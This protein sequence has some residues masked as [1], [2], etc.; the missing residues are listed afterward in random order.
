MDGAPTAP[1]NPLMKLPHGGETISVFVQPFS[2][3][4]EDDPEDF[5]S[6]SRYQAVPNTAAQQSHLHAEE[7]SRYVN[8]LIRQYTRY[9][10]FHNISG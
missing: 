9:N 1:L 6:S 8:T 5:Q 4:V 2:I 10:K 7:E 3:V